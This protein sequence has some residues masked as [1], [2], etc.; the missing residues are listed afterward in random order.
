VISIFDTQILNL[1]RRRREMGTMMAMGLTRSKLIIIFT[2]EGFLNAVMAAL[3]GAVYGVPLLYFTLKQGL[4]LPE[5]TDDY[6]I[7]GLSTKLYPYYSTQLILATVIVIF[8][9]VILVSYLPAR[10]ISQLQ[11]TDALRGKW[12]KKEK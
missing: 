4:A 9:L 7:A 8:L 1:F 10:K 6:N 3:I 11:P 2:L 12:T 5:A